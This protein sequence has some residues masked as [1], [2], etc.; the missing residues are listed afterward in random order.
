MD[1]LALFPLH[2]VLFPGMVLPLRVFEDRYLLL[3]QE[4]LER[5]RSFGIVLI[6]EGSEV[7]VPAVPYTVGT[8]AH[9]VRM[10]SERHRRL[11]VTVVGG[12][13][14][15]I[16]AVLQKEPYLLASVTYPEY[17]LGDRQRVQALVERARG[18]FSHYLELQ[19]RLA[20]RTPQDLPEGLDPELV[21]YVIA[22]TLQIAPQEKQQLLEETS[23]EVRLALE[24]SL[25]RR[26]S[27]IVSYF[28]ALKERK[29]GPWHAPVP[30]LGD[31][32]L[33]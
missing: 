15:R 29:A 26:E 31:F 20:E 30:S 2:T 24:L 6:K 32:S 5:K 1:E 14:F 21:S 25:L 27:Q 33:N 17:Q 12:R 28:L 7:G 22:S 16:E 10:S 13:P 4:V 9:L 11:R 3:M 8:T 18:Q 19:C 23:T